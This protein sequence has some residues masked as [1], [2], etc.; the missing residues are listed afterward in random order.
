MQPI[1]LVQAR[2]RKF[3]RAGIQEG[4]HVKE[5]ETRGVG[6]AGKVAVP[7]TAGDIVAVLLGFLD[8]LTRSSPQGH[9]HIAFQAGCAFVRGSANHTGAGPCLRNAFS[10]P[11]DAE[12]QILLPDPRVLRLNHHAAQASARAQTLRAA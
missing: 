2:E 9:K 6:A 5:Q 1:S 12:D 8:H 11:I 3:Q 10:A 4:L 7:D